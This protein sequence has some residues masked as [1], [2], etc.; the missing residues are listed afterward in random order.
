MRIRS[1]ILAMAGLA[2]LGGPA[3]AAASCTTHSGYTVLITRCDVESWC[4]ASDPVFYSQPILLQPGQT[5][6]KMQ[7]AYAKLADKTAKRPSGAYFGNSTGGCYEKPD[8]PEEIELRYM[9]QKSPDRNYVFM[10]F[11]VP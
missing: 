7:E 2:A 4:K 6:I 5:S 10:K 11:D 9:R 1:A 8:Q 3:V